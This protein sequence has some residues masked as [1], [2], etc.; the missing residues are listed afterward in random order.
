MSL[1]QVSVLSPFLTLIYINDLP[2]DLHA[3]I[4]LFGDDTL[5]SS[6]VDDIDKS[7][8][9]LNNYPIR[10]QEWDYQWKI[11]FDIDRTKPAHR[12]KPA[13]EVILI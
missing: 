12:P 13:H 10:I 11:S 1:P 8:S 5:L 3:Y 4:K 9:K 7:A 2:R 6:I